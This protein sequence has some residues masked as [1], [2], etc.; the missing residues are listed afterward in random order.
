MPS[1]YAAHILL[2][3][4]RCTRHHMVA[5]GWRMLRYLA[6]NI[7]NYNHGMRGVDGHDQFGKH[8]DGEHYLNYPDRVHSVAENPINVLAYAN[9]TG[10]R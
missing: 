5:T 8:L 3:A 1:R 2:R 4:P 7:D 6:G 9:S 10:C